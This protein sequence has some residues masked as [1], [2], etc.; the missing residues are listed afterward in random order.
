[1]AET[2]PGTGGCLCGTVRYRLTEPPAAFG[3]CHCQMCRRFSGGVEL[4]V[5]V[6]PGGIVWESDETVRTYRSSDW[7]E[8]GFCSV[9]GSSLFWRLTAPGPMRGMLALSAGTLDS[10]AGLDF[11]SEVYIDA[12]PHA[13]AFAGERK[14]MT[15][16]DVMA[17]VA[18]DMEGDSQ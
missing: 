7:A 9:C 4:G 5:Q 17:M 12:K 11:E 13:Y 3:A 14:R 15:E 2:N 8:R 18:Q 6:L 1:M 10:F 16:A